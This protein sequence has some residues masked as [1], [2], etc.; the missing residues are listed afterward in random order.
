MSGDPLQGVL[1]GS[2]E[3]LPQ[4]GRLLFIPFKGFSNIGKRAWL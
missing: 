1:H 2:D 3:I 4:A